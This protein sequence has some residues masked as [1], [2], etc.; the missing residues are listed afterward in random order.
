ME[1]PHCMPASSCEVSGLVAPHWWEFSVG[2]RGQPTLRQNRF[3]RG[4]SSGSSSIR[5]CTTPPSRYPIN[6]TI[7][8]KTALYAL[9]ILDLTLL[10]ASKRLFSCVARG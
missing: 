8:R 6:D 7:L 4:R 5:K 3:G 10:S 1:H 2:L 9:S